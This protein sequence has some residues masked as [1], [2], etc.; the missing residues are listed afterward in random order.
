MFRKPL[1]TM[2]VNASMIPIRK[3]LA[4]IAGI[5]GTKTSPKVLIARL[6]RFCLAAAAALASSFD[7]AVRPEMAINSS[8]TLFTT[9]VPKIICSW[10]EALNTPFTPS[11]SSTALASHLALS[12]N[13]SRKRVAQWAAEI[14]FSFFPTLS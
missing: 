5:I 8:Y 4:T 14:R 12:A 7:A 1:L 13:T 11:I 2:K 3:P 6:N 9:P 10:P